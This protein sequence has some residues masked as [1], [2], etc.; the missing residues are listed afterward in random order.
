MLFNQNCD[1]FWLE[2]QLQRK[3]VYSI[4]K[5]FAFCDS[6]SGKISFIVFKLNFILKFIFSLEG[7]IMYYFLNKIWLKI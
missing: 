6:K 1:L 5:N 3:Q 7:Y 2:Q 4:G